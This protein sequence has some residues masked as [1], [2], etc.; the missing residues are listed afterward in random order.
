MTWTNVQFIAEQIAR[1]AR[2]LA[3]EAQRKNAEEKNP[4]LEVRKRED[5]KQ[6][7]VRTWS[8]ANL[9]K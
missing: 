6:A 7:I 8:W 1:L 9:H 2:R 5:L 4:K 3:R